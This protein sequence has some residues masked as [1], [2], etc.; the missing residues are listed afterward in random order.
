MNVLGR[1]TI[2]QS[3]R[4]KFALYL[5]LSL[6]VFTGKSQC[7]QEC[8]FMLVSFPVENVR[9]KKKKGQWIQF[10]IYKMFYR[11]FCFLAKF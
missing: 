4:E 10:T 3:I 9:G 1:I 8:Y 11:A 6:Q 5:R 2:N 7:V